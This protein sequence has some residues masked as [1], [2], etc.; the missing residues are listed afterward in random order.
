MAPENQERRLQ[1]DLILRIVWR[2]DAQHSYA[3]LG[4]IT[5]NLQSPTQFDQIPAITVNIYVA[6]ARAHCRLIG[7][8]TDKYP[9]WIVCDMPRLVDSIQRMHTEDPDIITDL[10]RF[11]FASQTL[12]INKPYKVGKLRA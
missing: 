3:Q 7:I 5:S 10:D 2:S 4:Q 1:L 9:H 11:A 8:E 6:L 12:L